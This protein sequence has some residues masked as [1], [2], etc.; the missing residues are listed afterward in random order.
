MNDFYLS[1]GIILISIL[2]LLFESSTDIDTSLKK[3]PPMKIDEV[4][5]DFDK[6]IYPILKQPLFDDNFKIILPEDLPKIEEMKEKSNRIYKQ[7]DQMKN[8]LKFKKAN[9]NALYINEKQIRL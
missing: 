1:I 8:I 5:L 4:Q 6:P 7:S 3:T 9:Q 2:I